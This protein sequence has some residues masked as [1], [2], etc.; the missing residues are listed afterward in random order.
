MPATHLG[1]ID[2]YSP[3]AQTIIDATSGISL[4]RLRTMPAAAAYD[5]NAHP[6]I[7]STITHLNS[8]LTLRKISLR[9]QEGEMVD[10][11]YDYANSAELSNPNTDPGGGSGEITGAGAE[12]YSLD[13][14]L[15]AVSVLRWGFRKYAIAR[16]D[17]RVLAAMLQ[18]GPIDADG[19]QLRRFLSGDTDAELIADKIEDGKVSLLSPVYVWKVRRTGASWN[20]TN[21]IG[22]IG[23]PPGPVPTLPGGGN[24]LFMG[25]TASGLVN[26][27]AEMEL[28]W[29]SSIADDTW[30]ADFY[31]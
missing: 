25:A 10:C 29:Q 7:G 8:T 20:I 2:L 16:D 1:Q 28:T 24:W 9:T 26:R 23:T 21:P 11:A 12:S 4:T 17:K 18:L 22:K 5:L 19:N 13:I 27:A 3:G 31:S 30:D 15:E 14:S 6:A